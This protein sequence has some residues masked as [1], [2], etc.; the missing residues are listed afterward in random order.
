SATVPVRKWMW[1]VPVAASYTSLCPGGGPQ[2]RLKAISSGGDAGLSAP[3]STALNNR[4]PTRLL[5]IARLLCQT[6]AA[7]DVDEAPPSS[8]PSPGR[9]NRYLRR[10]PSPFRRGSRRG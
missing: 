5:T 8:L 9:L 10:S 4:H 7:N 6:W 2:K 1:N 3:A